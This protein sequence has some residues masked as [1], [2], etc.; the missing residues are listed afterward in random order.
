MVMAYIWTGM[1]LTA[2]LFSFWSGTG[3]ALSQ[4]VLEGAQS[5]VT[6]T[7]SMAGAVCLWSG[8]GRVM[9]C[10]GLNRILARG[11]EPVIGRLFPSAR[12]DPKVGEL[13]SANVCANLLGLGNAATP[14][15]LAATQRMSRYAKPGEASHE[16]CRLIVMNT[17]SIQLIPT[18]VAAVR[19]GLGSAAPFDILPAVWVTSLC[20]VTVGLLA[21]F[22]FQRVSKND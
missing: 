9:E 13:V 11:L 12:K 14:M 19:A 21:A 20:S 3:A 1:V 5:G 2:V 10:A 4:A 16:M 8:V 18:N 7:L 6:L 22:L 15:G 17:A